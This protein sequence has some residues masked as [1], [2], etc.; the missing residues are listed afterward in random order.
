MAWNMWEM[1]SNLV[2][3]KGPIGRGK[4]REK[5]KMHIKATLCF[6]ALL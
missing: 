1:R 5:L 6:C 3:P 4:G 2:R